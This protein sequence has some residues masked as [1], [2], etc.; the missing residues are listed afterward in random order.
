MVQADSWTYIAQGFISSSLPSAGQGGTTVTIVGSRLF[1][2]GSAIDRVTLAGIPATL[3]SGN[4][5]HVV[6]TANAGPLST[7]TPVGDVVVIGDTSVSTRL[8]GGWTYSEIESV[9]PAFGQRGTRVTI[10]GVRLLGDGANASS[11]S[12]VGI[13]G[14]FENTCLLC[15]L[16]FGWF[17]V[18]CNRSLITG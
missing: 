9:T 8:V 5:T 3:I 17:W 6:V 7:A 16:R 12:L 14:I 4:N 11:V 13:P 18:Q 1:G 2:G 10:S 15:R